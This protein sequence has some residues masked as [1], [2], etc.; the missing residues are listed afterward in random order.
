MS[1]VDLLKQAPLLQGLSQ[2]H[3]EALIAMSAIGTYQRDQ[4]VYEESSCGR[5]LYIILEGEVAVA[6]DPAR[7]GAIEQGS[8][9]PRVIHTFG[10]GESFG[11]IG[12][13]SGEPRG[14][15]IVANQD[16]TR[17]LIVSPQIFDHVLPAQTILSNIIHD[18]AA[19]LRTSNA[20]V[21]EDTLAN[22][23]L[24]IL[25]EEL[26]TGAYEC[27]PIIPF[28]RIVVIR[29]AES[30]I[31]SGPGRLLEQ[32]A[33]KESIEIGFFADTTALQQLAGPGT[34]SGAIIIRVFSRIC[35]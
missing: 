34:P 27:S 23:Y 12:L 11:V 18:L 21:I 19:K 16:H 15:T 17:L 25:V 29:N 22:Y 24:T 14:A 9:D 28:Q 1:D 13:I 3:L 7:S 8:I 5:E 31:L 33:V 10:P 26:S 20:R 2:E 6:V 35:G 4:V 30:F 32:S